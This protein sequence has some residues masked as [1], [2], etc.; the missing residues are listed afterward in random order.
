[1]D[2]RKCGEFK[3]SITGLSA[4][5]GMNTK[6]GS[7]DL[8]PWLIE[9]LGCKEGEKVLDV[10]CGNGAHLRL[11]SSI[12]GG[13]DLCVGIDRDPGM[14]D[15]AC[16]ASE[17]HSPP[18]RF[19]VL[20]MNESA[21]P[22]SEL[23]EEQFDLI[24]SVYALY[25]AED[26]MSVLDGFRRRRLRPGGRIA[27]VGP[28]ADNNQGWFDFMAQFMTLPDSILASTT[29]FMDDVLAHAKAN[30][31][32]V[33]T[34]DF[35]NTITLPSPEALREY[36]QANIYYEPEHD[37]AFEKLAAEHF[38]ANSAFSYV[39]RALMVVMR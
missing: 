22:E 33:A 31:T 9:R 8:K 7:Q 2:E 18:I 20:D 29:T 14:I 13:D 6:Y 16:K 17:G 24:Y 23:S 3:D 11:V 32:D 35:I 26:S 37:E 27:V 36:W 38:A 10:G 15:A 34:H 12:V 39:K 21:S 30:F 5:M 25:Y 1:M 19:R 4:R 28:Y